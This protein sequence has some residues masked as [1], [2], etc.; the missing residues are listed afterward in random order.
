MGEFEEWE[1]RRREGGYGRRNGR[2]RSG[3]VEPVR[4]AVVGGTGLDKRGEMRRE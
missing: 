1:F 2:G 4:G 3:Y